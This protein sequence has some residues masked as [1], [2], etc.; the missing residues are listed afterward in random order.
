MQTLKLLLSIAAVLFGGYFLFLVGA[1]VMTECGLSI[2]VN[3][4]CA[5]VYNGFILVIVG[6][7]SKQLWTKW[8]HSDTN[9]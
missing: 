9:H 1:V 6:V 7:A 4:A 8:I 2:P 3:M 5:V